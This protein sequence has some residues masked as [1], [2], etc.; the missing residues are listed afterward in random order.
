MIVVDTNVISYL[1]IEGDKTDAAQRVYKIDNEWVVPS[2]WRHE[3]LNVLSTFV[4]HGG[5]QIQQAETLW[6][7]AVDLFQNR[8][9]DLEA[10]LALKVS[11][12]HQISAYDAQFVVLA[13]KNQARLITEDRRLQAAF[14]EV[15]VS[16]G[17]YIMLTS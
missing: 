4:R 1:M 6:Y 5:G 15:A 2:L 8:E 13:L 3:F 7:Q 10:S 11:V 9:R 16:M 14:P 12:D 17:D